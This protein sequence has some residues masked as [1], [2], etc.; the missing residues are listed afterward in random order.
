MQASS[1]R[2][3]EGVATSPTRRAFA[4]HSRMIPPV[5]GCTPVGGS[6][7]GRR[8]C[9]KRTGA[10]FPL[11][12]ASSDQI[13]SYLHGTC[14]WR[15]EPSRARR[16]PRIPTVDHKTSTTFIHYPLSTRWCDGAMVRGIPKNI[17]CHFRGAEHLKH[18]R[19]HE[20]NANT[21]EALHS[22]LMRW[23]PGLNNFSS[24]RAE[25]TDMA[26]IEP[27]IVRG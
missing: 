9:T 14:P 17:S 22:Q 3:R 8:V 24:P 23:S 4:R 2:E 20:Q 19:E 12:T 6:G 10:P 27:S 11:D 1:G 7:G 16:I 25:E 26:S 5:Q 18:L 13:M 21:K 15:A